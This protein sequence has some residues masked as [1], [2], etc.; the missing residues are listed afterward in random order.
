M[1]RILVLMAVAAFLCSCASGQKGDL[2]VH[3]TYDLIGRVVPEHAAYF[4]VEYVAPENGNDVYELESRGGKIILRGNNGVSVASALNHYLEKYAHCEYSWN[5][6]NLDIPSPMPKVEKKVRKV[7]P[8]K[9]RHYFNYCTFNY[10]ASWWDWERWQ[11]EIDYMAL[12]G[13]NMPLAMTGQNA[14]WDRVYRKLGFTDEDMDKFFTGPAYFMW[15]W[16][17][18]IDAWGGPLPQSWKESHEELQKQI[19]K[20]ERELGMKPILPAFTGHVPP[21]FGERYP[22]ARLQRTNWEGRFDDTFILAP[23]DPMFKTIGNMFMEEQIKTFGTDHYYGAD[24]FNEM[25]P[26]SKELDYLENIGKSV[27]QS[28]ADVDPEAVWVMQGWLFVDKQ[29][30]WGPD[31]IQAYLGGIPDDG[32]IILDL[33]AEENPVWNRSE[34]F[35]G[36]PWIWCML[37]NFGGRNMLYG[38]AHK[39]ALEPSRVLNHPDA[40]N[41]MGI[42][43][44]PEGIEQNPVIYSL[45]FDQIWQREPIYVESW[46]RDY[47]HKRYGQKIPQMEQAWKI[48]LATAYSHEGN[49]ESSIMARPTFNKDNTWAYTDIPYDPARMK[50]VWE[51]MLSCADLLAGNECYEYDLLM[52]GKQVLANHARVIQ[53]KFGEDYR[54]DDLVAFDRNYKDYMTLIDDLDALMATHQDLLLGK[55]IEDARE[56]GTTEAEKD[57]YER[58]ARNI[59]TLWGGKDAFLHD[60]ASKQW[61]GLFKGFY[62]VRWQMFL[63]E[64]RRCIDKNLKFDV[65]GTDDRIREWEWEWVNSTGGFSAEPQGNTV[66]I[67]KELYNKYKDIV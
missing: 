12:H 63:D 20:R 38:N 34:S 39:L 21:T 3:A 41:L 42:G 28:M 57:L 56:W 64:V 35:Y 22:E 67:S 60:Y 16:A 13:I 33:W 8:Y 30:F 59:V 4:K 24:T 51:L 23:D 52:V 1:K 50:D 65:E 6:S 49:Y 58:N 5:A 47:A 40:G 55:W 15:F 9:Y 45:L 54:T 46:I 53:R 32:M 37:H 44:V 7:T 11:K 18:N 10:T 17:G 31:Q 25:V 2:N 27:Y 26:P 66:E 14:V 62:K 48:L 43:A 61:A 29:W 19:L 36:K